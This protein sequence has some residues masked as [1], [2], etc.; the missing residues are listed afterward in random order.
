MRTS[1]TVEIVWNDE[2]V[3]PGGRDIRSRNRT[4]QRYRRRSRFHKM[5]EVIGQDFG[6]ESWDTYGRPQ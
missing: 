2:G 1:E 5:E 3:G 4:D 6:E